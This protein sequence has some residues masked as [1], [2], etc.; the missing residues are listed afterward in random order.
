MNLSRYY[1]ISY[2]KWVWKSIILTLRKIFRTLEIIQV[3]KNK[4]MEA[5]KISVYKIESKTFWIYLIVRVMVIIRKWIKWILKI[6]IVS[7][8][9]KR[10]LAVSIEWE[11]I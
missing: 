7:S 5:K 3:T 4:W 8:G 11:S 9:T 2:K 6:K 10:G 1:L